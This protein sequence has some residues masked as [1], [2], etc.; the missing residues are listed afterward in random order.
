VAWILRYLGEVSS[1]KSGMFFE[2]IDKA[3]AFDQGQQPDLSQADLD[4]LPII[5]VF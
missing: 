1:E 2:V 5:L 4:L 3:S